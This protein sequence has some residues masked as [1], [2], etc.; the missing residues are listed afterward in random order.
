[1]STNDL[2]IDIVSAKSLGDYR[3][4]IIFSDGAVRIV[5]FGSFLRRSH[6]PAIRKYLN[7]DLFHQFTVEGGDLMWGDYDLCFPLGD[8]YD[9]KI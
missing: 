6:H 1:M 4:E 8:L 2:I 5:D 7:I 3:L 9:G